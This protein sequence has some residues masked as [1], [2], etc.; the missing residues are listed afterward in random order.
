MLGFGPLG[1]H[2]LGEVN[3]MN[4]STVV[5]GVFG[6]GVAGVL[7][8]TTGTIPPAIGRGVAGTIIPSTLVINPHRLLANVLRRLRK[9]GRNVP[10]PKI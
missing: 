5:P 4:P 6:V 2:A 1:K 10:S 7:S 9:L 8:P 3:S